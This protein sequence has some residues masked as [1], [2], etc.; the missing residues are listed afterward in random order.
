MYVYLM[1]VYFKGDKPD[2]PWIK[3]AGPSTPTLQDPLGRLSTVSNKG[4][5]SGFRLWP[6]TVKT[7]F[8]SGFGHYIRGILNPVYY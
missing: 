1:Y 5:K 7:E 3:A 8:G 6:V 2:K 4:R